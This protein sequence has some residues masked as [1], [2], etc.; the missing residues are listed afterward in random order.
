MLRM[1]RYLPSDN[2]RYGMRMVV[3]RLLDAADEGRG[4]DHA[5]FRR[6]FNPR[7]K[8][9]LYDPEFAES[10]ALL[11]PLYGYADLMKDVP[12]E[13]SYLTVRQHADLMFHLPGILAKVDRMSMANGLEVRVPLLSRKMVEFC[14]DLPDDAK[15]NWG[16]GKRILREAISGK[17]P[18]GALS[19]Q[20]AGFL[21]PVDQWFRGT[22][23]MNNVFGDHL[24]VA[25]SSSP[26]LQWG[27][28]E[29][30]WNGHK[31]GKIDAGFILLSILQFINFG[32]QCKKFHEASRLR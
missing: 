13:R 16:K 20:K 7:M 29:K 19:R 9:R 5:S 22:G 32:L 31:Q 11:D 15:R 8:Q 12:K 10:T 25:R 4:R 23:P 17:A 21:P 28:V 6:I 2:R 3:E 14:L 30:L 27:E 26:C 24:A 1:A 18:A